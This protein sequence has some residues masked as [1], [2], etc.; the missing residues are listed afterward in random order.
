MNIDVHDSSQRNI[1]HYAVLCFWALEE[2]RKTFQA[3]SN[4]VAVIK[5]LNECHRLQSP[6]S[7]PIL[8]R[9]VAAR[10]PLHYAALC[11]ATESIKALCAILAEIYGDE[12]PAVTVDNLLCTPMH[13]AAFNGTAKKIVDKNTTNST[14]NATIVTELM[15]HVQCVNSH[16]DDCW[17]PLHCAIYTERADILPQLLQCTEN[18]DKEIERPI[19]CT[20]SMLDVD[21]C[22]V[23]MAGY[24]K[25]WSAF[26][27]ESFQA[28]NVSS[29]PLSTQLHPDCAFAA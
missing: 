2:S 10:T 7:N 3:A 13:Y 23:E 29:P 17:S 24:G 1:W 14:G 18:I 5:T 16:I 15:T 19:D 21:G 4:N 28:H 25:L 22:R 12:R 11:D 27:N 26:F 9:C 8:A 6:D 20:M